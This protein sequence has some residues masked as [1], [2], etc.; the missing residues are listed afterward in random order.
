M[1]LKGGQNIKMKNIWSL[2]LLISKRIMIRVITLEWLNIY[3]KKAC[4]ETE[5]NAEIMIIRYSEVFIAKK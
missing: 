2:N 5:F 1:I 3:F 4:K